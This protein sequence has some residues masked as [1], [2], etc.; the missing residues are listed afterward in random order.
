VYVVLYESHVGRTA[1]ASVVACVITIRLNSKR[2]ATAYTQLTNISGSDV[3]V[4][5]HLRFFYQL[6]LGL[7][8]IQ[9]C[10]CLAFVLRNLFLPVLSHHLFGNLKS[11]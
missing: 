3:G 6:R 9:L 10:L 11:A 8:R 7:Q 4:K 1:Y 5:R 2:F